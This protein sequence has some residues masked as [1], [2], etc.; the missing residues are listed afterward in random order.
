MDSDK[1]TFLRLSCRQWFS[2]IIEN[3][4]LSDEFFYF[5]SSH[6]VQE[7]FSTNRVGDE[8]GKAHRSERVVLQDPAG[9]A[10]P[11]KP[12]GPQL[13]VLPSPCGFRLCHHLR[14]LSAPRRTLRHS[15]GASTGPT[16]LPDC[17]P[18]PNREKGNIKPY[19]V[20]LAIYCKEHLKHFFFF[21]GNTQKQGGKVS[22][23]FR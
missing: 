8:H 11:C 21:L 5:R 10:W 18:Y 6:S 23:I 14:F 16:G 20:L 15:Q 17:S 4:F 7:L 3:M 13:P 12:R 22:F 19:F 9:H 2:P 1:H